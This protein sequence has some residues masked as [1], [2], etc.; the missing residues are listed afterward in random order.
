MRECIVKCVST[1]EPVLKDHSSGDKIGSLK[2]GGLF[3]DRF[4]YTRIWDLLPGI[5]G[6]SRQVVFHVSGLSRLVSLYVRKVTVVT[7]I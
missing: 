2:T 7:A 3:P 5:C 6:S 4:N 1:V